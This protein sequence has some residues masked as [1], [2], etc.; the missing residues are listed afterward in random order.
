MTF[1]NSTSTFWRNIYYE[2]IVEHDPRLRSINT[3][4]PWISFDRIVDV[5]RVAAINN[6]IIASHPIAI[7][8]N[9]LAPESRKFRRINKDVIYKRHEPVRV[10]PAHLPLAIDTGTYENELTSATQLFLD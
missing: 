3:F 8:L 6:D 5:D 7:Y 4:T 2:S 9:K 1:L 10:T